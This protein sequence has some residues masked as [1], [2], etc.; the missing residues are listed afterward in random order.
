[1]QDLFCCL[2]VTDHGKDFSDYGKW[3]LLLLQ[4]TSA[5]V[6]SGWLPDGDMG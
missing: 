2:E 1:M 5:P 4:A 3:L 6:S